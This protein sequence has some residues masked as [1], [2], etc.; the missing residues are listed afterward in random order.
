MIAEAGRA[1]TRSSFVVPSPLAARQWELHLASE[2]LGA[3]SRVWETPPI[4]T[5]GAWLERRWRE[6]SLGLRTAVLTPSQ[7]AA[8]WRRV[9]A[10]SAAGEALIGH[11]GAAEWAAAAAALLRRWRVAPAARHAM[12]QQIDFSAF[13]DWERRYREI[14]AAHGWLDPHDLEHELMS[15]PPLCAEAVTVADLGDTYP[16]RDALLEHLA[17]SGTRI[18]QQ[19]A[20]AV[21]GRQC[22]A[23]FPDAS[24]ELRAALAWSRQLLS[25]Q[26]DARV[27]VIVPGLEQR[28]DEVARLAAAELRSFGEGAVWVDGG[29][30]AR[31]PAVGAAVNALTLLSST[32]GYGEFGRWLRSPFFGGPNEQI[33]RAKL[34]RKL[35]QDLRSQV[36]F[37]VAYLHCGIRE[38]LF[39]HAPLIASALA[40]G[41]AELGAGTHAA[42]SRWAHRWTRFLSTLEWRPPL[43]RYALLGWQSA[44]DEL[45]RL[46]PITGEVSLASAL[47]EL[48]RILE[49]TAL[50][51]PLALRGV[52]VL[53]HIDDVGPGYAGVW[54]TGFTD[55]FWP[56]SPHGNPLLPL[57]LQRSLGMPYAS[58]Q[59]AERR[60]ASALA[61]LVA[62]TS[63]L[64]VSWPARI[65]DYETEQSPAIVAWPRLDAADFDRLIAPRAVA[66]T[67]ARE[68]LRDVPPPF[69]ATTLPGSTG[70]L[71]RQARCPVRA[72]CEDRLRARPLEPLGFGVNARFRGIAAHRAA[73]L[74]LADLPSQQQLVAKSPDALADAAER[75]VARVF[76]TARQPLRN[77]FELELE[78][79]R[80]VLTEFLAIESRRAPFRVRAVEQRGEIALE[81]R[82]LV[83]RVD[84]LDELA[85]GSLAILDYKTSERA[86]GAD[87]FAPR[88]RDAQV[89]LYAT[90]A[91]GVVG[92]AVV[93]RLSPNT[94][95]YSGIWFDATF[96]GRRSHNARQSVAE[97]LAEWRAQLTALA[98]EF[99]AGDTRVLLPN[100]DEA[101][102]SYAPL[103]RIYEQ[104]GLASGTT[105]TW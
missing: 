70:A 8:L 95:G 47:T 90:Q 75:A 98:A 5:Y 100:C 59:D 1:A 14:L 51:S 78:Q 66:R 30:L 29:E 64:V 7:S 16:A 11:A 31:D 77:L 50:A 18:V 4:Q 80:R 72:F 44:L 46:T 20:P 86:T 73:E 22:T 87:W 10:E 13:L 94:A 105:P 36:P 61:R 41:L 97:Q 48:T 2:Q 62:R 43:S 79:L 9:I 69:T 52:H 24:S 25:E 40:R 45:A 27:A 83:V 17:A 65:Y 15:R 38:Q 21:V 49:R 88:L 74:L 102:G 96:P 71:G 23:R 37:G 57:A 92:A 104:L 82:T 101:L 58:P 54:A 55:T 91:Q 34:D 6:S 28:R 99:I 42:P 63:E 89:P 67:P 93:A 84:R 68:T 103:T 60:S 85:D 32:A 76:G 56:E 26:P 19:S 35:R 12:G 39:A 33:A 53:R 81:G 3:G